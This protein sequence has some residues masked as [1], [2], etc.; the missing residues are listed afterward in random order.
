MLEI[1]INNQQELIDL[2]PEDI[3][4]LI[5]K[6]FTAA[7]LKD[8]G[9]LSVTFMDDN[10]IADLNQT[11]R[12]KEGPTD[13]LSF[14]QDE[15][16]EFPAPEDENYLPLIGDI[17]I[18][19]ETAKKQAEEMGHPLDRE[20]KIL[21]IHGILHL[22]GYDHEDDEEAAAMQEKEKEILKTLETDNS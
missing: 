2:K 4:E 17:M 12:K 6:I 8:H 18:S 14:P 22:Y 1:Y 9:E 15:G 5:K 7:K 13:I 19:I 3:T 10:A 21:L 16:M 11:Y 20:L